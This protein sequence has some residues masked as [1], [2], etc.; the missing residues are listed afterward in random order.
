MVRENAV[1][2]EF[3]ADWASY[4]GTVIP[5]FAGFWAEWGLYFGGAIWAFFEGET[6]VL[7]AAAA[8]RKFGTVDP[9]LLLISVWIGS[10]AGD[11]LW[12]Y[13]GRKFG[14]KALHKIPAAEKRLASAFRFLDRNGTIF[15]LTFRFVYGIRNV[16]SAA[17]G[18]AGMSRTRFTVLNIIGA[19]LWAGTFVAAGWY[20]AAMIG[21]RHVWWLLSIAGFAL[22]AFLVVKYLRARRQASDDA[23]SPKQDAAP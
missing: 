13:L 17:C 21:K 14:S 15:V 2:T 23:A 10:C 19:G 9:W 11:Q 4:L 22:F 12:F 7:F 8:G 6:F 20:L 1:L 5:G 18:I 3:L 16:S